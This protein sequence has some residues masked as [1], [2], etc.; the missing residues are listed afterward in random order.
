MA[1]VGEKIL[2]LRL[3]LFLVAQPQFKEFP[4]NPIPMVQIAKRLE[5]LITSSPH[6]L[7]VIVRFQTATNFHLLQCCKVILNIESNV[8]VASDSSGASTSFPL[9]DLVDIVA[10]SDVSGRPVFLHDFDGESDTGNEIS[11]YDGW[12]EERME[13][14]DNLAA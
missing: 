8:L 14:F 12:F 2:Q 4:M 3:F 13:V 5:S 11:D 6:R 7:P 9:S 10:F 1:A